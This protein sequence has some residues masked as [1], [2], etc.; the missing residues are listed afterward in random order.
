LTNERSEWE[1]TT[2]VDDR[3]GNSWEEKRKK[4]RQDWDTRRAERFGMSGTGIGMGVG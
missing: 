2:T 1:G 3:D 4:G